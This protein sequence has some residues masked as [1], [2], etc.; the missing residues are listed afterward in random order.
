MRL[1]TELQFYPMRSSILEKQH[2]FTIAPFP[3]PY[4]L[5]P[6]TLW[7]YIEFILFL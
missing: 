1:L 4:G 2:P 3:R 5:E 7:G 6:A